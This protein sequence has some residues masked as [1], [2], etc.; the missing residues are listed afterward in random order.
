[1]SFDIKDNG[2]RYRFAS[3][4]VRNTQANK[5][6]F[7]RVLLGPMFRRYARH[8]T[9]GATV[10]PDIKPGVPNWTL[11][12]GEEELARFKA[13]AF[14]HFVQWYDGETDEDHAAA[15]YFNING[16]EYVKEKLAASTHRPLEA[17][18]VGGVDP[19]SKP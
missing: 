5:I 12:T 6:D 16:A 18:N 10:Y 17:S 2:E 3:G 9:K 11:A 4:M 14:R 7:W 19:C 1:M 13:S 15:V 8:M